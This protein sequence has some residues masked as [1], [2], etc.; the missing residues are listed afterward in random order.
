MRKQ[1]KAELSKLKALLIDIFDEIIEQFETVLSLIENFDLKASELVL[2]NDDRIDEMVSH[3][4]NECIQF[5]ATQFPVASDLRLVYSIMLI[6]MHL[7]R[8]G[9]LLYNTTKGVRRINEIGKIDENV[10]NELHEMASNTYEVVRRARDA[11]EKSDIA[12]VD[13]LSVMDEKV[14]EAFKKFIRNLGKFS[15]EEHSLEWYLSVILLVRYMERA[16]DQAVDIGKRVAYMLTG[17]Q[18]ELS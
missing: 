15:S 11:F 7:E 18:A 8:I 3:L 1:F 13:E 5:V 17:R 14:D 10:M 4:E 9:D 12:I 16:A 2:R 6:N